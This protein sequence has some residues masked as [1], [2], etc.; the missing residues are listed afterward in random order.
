LWPWN[1]MQAG[2]APAAAEAPEAK[3]EKK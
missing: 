2:A 3:P 1:M